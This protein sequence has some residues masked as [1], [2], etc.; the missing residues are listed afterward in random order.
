MA[1]PWIRPI[2]HQSGVVLISRRSVIINQLE[3]QIP[4][5]ACR[6]VK[7]KIRNK[8]HDQHDDKCL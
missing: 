8:Q 6:R 2:V 5:R 3:I 4:L 7:K 1:S